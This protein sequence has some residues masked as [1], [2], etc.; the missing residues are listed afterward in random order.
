LSETERLS[1]REEWAV[2]SVRKGE[3]ILRQAG[4]DWPKK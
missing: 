3:A 2:K 1:L 4:V